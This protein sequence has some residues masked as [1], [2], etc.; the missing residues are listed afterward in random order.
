MKKFYTLILGSMLIIPVA[1][2]C[3]EKS[4]SQQEAQQEQE[5]KPVVL[6]MDHLGDAKIVAPLVEALERANVRTTVQQ[7]GSAINPNSIVVAIMSPTGRIEYS[8]ST[9]DTS[10]IRLALFRKHELKAAE[11]ADEK[12][13]EH[14]ATEPRLKNS[15][16]C[17]ADSRGL[18]LSIDPSSC[19]DTLMSEIRRLSQN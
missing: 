3:M 14:F 5:T 15:I 10:A 11:E 16:I 12:L 17:A 7:R 4:L 9:A 1:L 6:L 19:F 2:Y 18:T 13:Y 8:K